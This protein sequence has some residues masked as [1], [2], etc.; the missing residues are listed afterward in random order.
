[1]DLYWLGDYLLLRGENVVVLVPSPSVQ[2]ML[3]GHCEAELA[4]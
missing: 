2:S 4:A 3:A 1:V